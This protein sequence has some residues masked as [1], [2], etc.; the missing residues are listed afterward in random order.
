M[1]KSNTTNSEFKKRRHRPS[2]QP[3][4]QNL[5][6]DKKQKTF[7]TDSVDI[8]HSSSDEHLFETSMSNSTAAPVVSISQ[9][10]IVRIAQTVKEFLIGDLHNL[11]DEK[12]K[13]VLRELKE[14]KI[15]YD[16]L[17][18][19]W[20]VFRILL[21]FMKVLNHGVKESLLRLNKYNKKNPQI[22]N[23]SIN[24]ELTRLRSKLAYYARFLVRN[25]KLK[26]TWVVDGKIYIVDNKDDKH[27]VRNNDDFI[28]MLNELEIEPQT[29]WSEQPDEA[30]GATRERLLTHDDGAM[31]VINGDV[32][33]E[34]WP[35]I[36]VSVV[37]VIIVNLS[38]QPYSGVPNV[39]KDYVQI[40]TNITVFQMEQKDTKPCPSPSTGELQNAEFCILHNEKYELF[41]REHECPCCK[42]CG[43]T[44][45][46]CKGLTD[47][48]E[49]I[50]NIKSSNAFYEIEQNLLEIVENVKRISTSREEN[51]KSLQNKKREI[52]EEIKLTRTKVNNHL[53]KLQDDLLN[54]LCTIEQKESIKIRTSL[55][56]LRKKKKEVAKYQARFDNIKNIQ[57]FGGVSISSERCDWPTLKRKN[58]QAQSILALPTRSIESLT[59][60]LKKRINTELS[61]VRGCSLLPDGRTVF[62]CCVPNLIRVLKTDGSKDFEINNIGDTFDVVFIGDGSIAVT[63]GHS[64]RINI[65]DIKNKNLEKTIKVNSDNDGVVYK[66]GHLIYCAKEKGL[67]M[68]SLKDESITNV[69]S[70]KLSVFSYV[71]TFRDKLFYTNSDTHSVTCCD[72][73]GNI[74]WTFC[75][76][77]ILLSPFGISVDKNGNVFVVG[78]GSHNVVVISPDGQSFRQLLSRKDGLDN[79]QA[80]HYDQSTNNLLVALRT[81]EAYLFEVNYNL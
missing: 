49:M 52:E 6:T 63:S 79:P 33:N 37:F 46:D 60:K 73:H 42:T 29:E 54:E 9:E 26:S 13:P 53:D 22:A 31:S 77:S 24:Q 30:T 15:K 39:T 4:P 28:A 62:S 14:L 18:K 34:S 78:W 61:E 11:I 58:S 47:I 7:D 36:G 66:D 50:K 44:H 35:V 69:T 68:I 74:L 1:Q 80:L 5:Q 38:N 72:Y 23:I 55:T 8:L 57:E 21:L 65:I 59:L 71:A 64:D 20:K 3:S 67:Q 25:K 43:K 32:G 16:D 70:N 19:K 41:C 48:N 51:L 17:D 75:H 76:I 56:S 40:V 12:Q 27:I 45:K 10:D 81:N 2:S